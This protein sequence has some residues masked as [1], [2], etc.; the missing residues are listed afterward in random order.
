MTQ[1]TGN[2]GLNELEWWQLKLRERVQNFQNIIFVIE[3]QT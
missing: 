3:L 1:V 2:D